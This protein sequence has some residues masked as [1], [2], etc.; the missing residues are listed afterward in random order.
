MSSE[1][2][3]EEKSPADVSQKIDLQSAEIEKDDN[4]ATGENEKK[5]E[6]ENK[7][8]FVA[9]PTALPGQQELADH[10]EA[11][12]KTTNPEN[13]DRLI[14][15]KEIPTLILENRQNSEEKSPEDKYP[16]D[17]SEAA[18]MKYYQKQ[19]M[20]PN[21]LTQITAPDQPFPG[22]TASDYQKRIEEKIAQR[23][24][25]IR[26]EL[27]GK[28]PG[29]QKWGK[30]SQEAFRDYLNWIQSKVVPTTVT[31]LS[32]AGLVGPAGNPVPI[33]G[34]SVADLQTDIITER[35][36]VDLGIDYHQIPNI[37]T[38]EKIEST[39]NWANK[40]MDEVQ[41]LKLARRDKQL[42]EMIDKMGFPAQWH[43]Q[44]GQDRTAWRASVGEMI[45]L[46]SRIKRAV[47]VIDS[48]KIPVGNPPGSKIQ[49]R[50]SNGRI[51]QMILAMPAD[52]RQLNP[53]NAIII[54]QSRKWL[55]MADERIK[56]ALKDRNL[57]ALA[58][59]DTVVP[60][61]TDSTGKR[62]SAQARLDENGQLIDLINP[63][64]IP[65][66]L[67][68]NAHDVNLLEERYT[69]ELLPNG[70][71]K[72]I[73]NIQAQSVPFFSPQNLIYSN[74]GKPMQLS[75]REYKPDDL[76][77]VKNGNSTEYVMAKDLPGLQE[78]QKLGFYGQKALVL[79]MYVAMLAMGS[80][81]ISAAIKGAIALGTMEAG[82]SGSRLT[83]TAMKGVL[84]LGLGLSNP[85]SNAYWTSRDGGTASSVRNWL[86]LSSMGW[87]L[88]EQGATRL[89]GSFALQ[90]AQKGHEIELLI[91]QSG[92]A[93]RTADK[94][95]KAVM[96]W[97]QLPMGAVMVSE[98]AHELIHW[99]PSGDSSAAEENNRD[100][101]GP[102]GQR[103]E[104]GVLGDLHRAGQDE[105]KALV[106]K[107]NQVLESLESYKRNL[108]EN[109]ADNTSKEKVRDLFDTAVTLLK[110]GSEEE[111]R[112][113]LEKLSQNLGFSGT[114][115]ARLEQMAGSKLS[116]EQLKSLMLPSERAQNPNEAMRKYV[117]E[118]MKNR[119]RDVQTASKMIMLAMSRDAN[120]NLKDSAITTT[121]AV[122]DYLTRKKITI[123]AIDGSLSSGMV[124]GG[125]VSG[126]KQTI[127]FDK[128][129]LIRSLKEDLSKPERTD[130]AQQNA[131]QRTKHTARVVAIGGELIKSGG[132]DA[133][134]YA[135]ILQDV[136]FVSSMS[137]EQKM[138]SLI[139][140]AVG[141]GSE[142]SL[143]SVILALTEQ[144]KIYNAVP[145]NDRIR[146]IGKKFNTSTDFVMAN[147]RS[148]ASNG[149]DPDL[150]AMAAALLFAGRRSLESKEEG[151]AISNGIA[152]MYK[153]IA[154]DTP[155][156]VFAE[157]VKNAL[158]QQ[159][160][161]SDKS[162]V[163]TR[164]D[165]AEALDLM[166]RKM[167]DEKRA[168][169][170]KQITENLIA[171][172]EN[173]S[174][175]ERNKIM[176][177]L[178]VDDRI[179]QLA[180]G[181][182]ELFRKLQLAVLAG[183]DPRSM[184]VNINGR[185]QNFRADEEKLAISNWKYIKQLAE[186]SDPTFR[187]DALAYAEGLAN[188]TAQS[189]LT[190]VRV[191]AIDVLGEMN[192]KEVIPML[193]DLVKTN[194]DASVRLGALQA[195]RKMPDE[196]FPKLV[197]SRLS[198]EQDARVKALLV[199]LNYT[200]EKSKSSAPDSPEKAT[201][202]FEKFIETIDS[203]YPELAPFHNAAQKK[204]LLNNFPLLDHENFIA[205]A[206][207][208][209]L[210][211][212][213]GFFSSMPTEARSIADKINE[214]RKEQFD[215]L[216]KLAKTDTSL[217]S[218]PG[219][220]LAIE[221][222]RVLLGSIISS[223]GKFISPE[224]FNFVLR[225]A[226]SR[227]ASVAYEA[228]APDWSSQAAKVL[229]E[230]S[231]QGN[232]ERDL[233]AR[234]VSYTLLSSGSKDPSARSRATLLE[235]WKTLNS[236]PGGI[237]PIP[238]SIYDHIAGTAKERKIA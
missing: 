181:E 234:L 157:K 115:I 148:T 137:K 57:P 134:Q 58:Y 131:D 155:A 223:N 30:E 208:A 1:I 25:A 136:L 108:M 153:S 29:G 95:S 84:D 46:Y 191:A 211:A 150:R 126:E 72:V 140:S 34:R 94:V 232:S 111:K 173:A 120:G 139:G 54:E 116:E 125:V 177:L 236:A 52:L 43:F 48:N 132:I 230:L 68:K 93:A 162:D 11:R 4:E 135:S 71:I 63:S 121:I 213:A 145:S 37:A 47:D 206:R 110:V 214:Q 198:L 49:S 228:V 179:K 7:N 138:R 218:T 205:Q 229:L 193:R 83:L 219:Q 104:G 102:G 144:D 142:I 204:W 99:K 168:E 35:T 186:L 109:A 190:R 24:E 156:G 76:V 184:S 20:S 225:P 196:L 220:K 124:P 19:L 221:Q 82:I 202:E 106:Q 164:L 90:Q 86:F 172:F 14:E 183:L 100:Y 53:A 180:K 89:S 159:L 6:S 122:D 8:D 88:A 187:R 78:S 209:A 18:V 231:A 200:I 42:A 27:E 13:N 222:A 81:Q 217:A 160:D 169:V 96:L 60:Q 97:G 85:V 123:K 98:L 38:A 40:S 194:S 171:S 129:F 201:K 87:G 188:G 197:S 50:D 61:V 203:R 91:N 207:K 44:E 130:S 3:T 26:Q 118:L 23:Q 226:R 75:E 114:D 215:Q 74:V 224:K 103:P 22:E 174:S 216:L 152:A 92:Q 10:R 227:I 199:D 212:R 235:A 161:Q 2:A 192:A 105:N 170:N 107:P 55:A 133:R 28:P 127:N 189:K 67:R 195:L 233:T 178:M 151:A 167:P 39:I 175:A 64:N 119:S 15:K 166:S 16:N 154:A 62:I 237:S 163:Q 149:V 141:S 5:N 182:P 128:D 176:D 66:D 79:G 56:N 112:A 41:E 80:I 101:N 17:A 69:T 210:D 21:L 117:D 45:D 65:P 70:N 147:L 185:G 113:F 9:Q 143:N 165:A 73:Q 158:L 77:Q 33:N 146:D 32:Q 51:E 31:E 36:R 238:Q 12:A 59:T